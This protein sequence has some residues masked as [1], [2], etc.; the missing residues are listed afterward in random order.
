VTG[1]TIGP[2][3]ILEELG[4]GGMGVVYKARDSRLR[5]IVAVKVLTDTDQDATA[6]KRFL[7]E[8]QAASAL[9]HPG[10]VTVHDILEQDDRA[11][12]VMEYVEGRP[13][14]ELIPS[15][16]LALDAAL[17]YAIQICEAL[18]VAH[19][20]GIVHRDLKPSNVIVC[21]NG[22]LKI[23]DFGLAKFEPS[24]SSDLTQSMLTKAHVFLGTAA[25]V[26]PEQSLNHHVD[27][28]SDIF[29]FGVTLH[30]MLTGT[31]PFRGATNL[32]LLF[33][34]NR[35][36]PCTIRQCR[37]DLPLSLEA[38]VLKMLEKRS[39]DRCQSI[40]EVVASLRAI[41]REPHSEE[42]LVATRPNTAARAAA[43]AAPAPARNAGFSTSDS[44]KAAIAV[45]PFRGISADP[46]SAHISEGIASEIIR[47]LSGVPGI[48]V[49]SQLASFRFQSSEHDL[50]EVAKSLNARY[51][52]TGSVRHGGKRIRVIAELADALEGTQLWSRTYDHNTD[53]LFA[54]QEQIANAIATDVSGPLL[55]VRA[56]HAGG[57]PSGE[58]DAAGLV[59]KANRSVTHAYHKEGIEDAI[60]ALRQAIALSPD[61]AVAHAYLGLYL[62]QR[63]VNGFSTEMEKDRSAAFQAIERGMQLA[64]SD[65]EV[66]EN[67]G[68]VL[69][70]CGKYERS[71]HVLRRTVQIAQF[72]LIAWGYLGLTLGWG[73]DEPEMEE[74]Q[75]IF[76]RL[77]RDAPDH[78]SQPYWLYFKSGVCV[79]QGK[80]QEA[81]DCAQRSTELQPR[82]LIAM[83]AH[84]NALG[85]LGRLPE[86]F[87]VI[88]RALALNPDV[89]QEAYLTE[90]MQIGRTRERIM[91]HIGGLVAA[92]IFKEP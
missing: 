22:R 44:Q 65:A 41:E 12:L 9:S 2:Y 28:R 74:A 39:E 63:V 3:E 70:H 61:L 77:I 53:D 92:G 87:E 1:R 14:K 50:T 45:L 56:D 26:S 58:L 30:E 33:D 51:V 68:L 81:T 5:R 86:A 20:A 73:G 18:S 34:I 72:D 82:F 42:T 66:L 80:F 48:R 69:L 89:K 24:A 29:S 17:D 19:A 62:M 21:P 67:A 11:C 49:A 32:E 46:A 71:V 57:T 54:V 59:R 52:L 60:G 90:L 6:K 31:W 10:I 35:G 27:H 47:A 16:G 7:R 4:Q 25:Y 83:V 43:A 36:I 84:A 79:R 85:H 38:L 37:P 13:L 91:P 64:P 15:G 8:A 78:P 75:A 23:L 55:R 88:G 40:G 76:D